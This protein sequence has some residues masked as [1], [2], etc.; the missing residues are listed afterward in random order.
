MT[1]I[2]LVLRSSQKPRSKNFGINFSGLLA[3]PLCLCY[4]YKCNDYLLLPK[5][6]KKNAYFG[7]EK[8]MRKKISKY[9]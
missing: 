8:K 4:L 9:L 2:N 3:H 1:S 5:I 6:A 7:N